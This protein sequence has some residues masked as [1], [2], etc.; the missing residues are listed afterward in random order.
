MD[1]NL[2]DGRKVAQSGVRSWV[3]SHLLAASNGKHGN[4]DCAED[5]GSAYSEPAAAERHHIAASVS[6]VFETKL[7]ILKEA[8]EEIDAGLRAREKLNQAFENQ[9]DAEISECQ[10]YLG[11][12]PYPWSEGFQPKVEFLRLSLHKSL[13]TRRKDK[14]TE[15]LA[16]WGDVTSLLEKKRNLLM[17]YQNLIATK[18]SLEKQ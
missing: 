5:A 16:Y 6:R 13:L 8:M 4:S 3:R 9:I 14:R 11:K 17:E 15:Q 7:A 18:D 2:S 12:L 1:N 10:D